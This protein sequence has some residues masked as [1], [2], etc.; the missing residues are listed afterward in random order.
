M[1][2]NVEVCSYFTSKDGES[3]NVRDQILSMIDGA[4]AEAAPG[5]RIDLEIYNKKWKSRRNSSPGK[6]A[7]KKKSKKLNDITIDED[8][9]VG[10]LLSASWDEYFREVVQTERYKDRCGSDVLTSL[11]EIREIWDLK[12]NYENMTDEERKKLLGTSGIYGWLGDMKHARIFMK[13]RHA[14]AKKISLALDEIP[15]DP[16]IEVTKDA[17]DAFLR[18]WRK[19]PHAALGVASRLLAVRR[20]DSFCSVNRRCRTKLQKALGIRDIKLDNYW[21]DC[22]GIIRQS[23]WWKAP[24]PA[25]IKRARLWD[26]RMALVDFLVCEE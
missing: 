18:H 7:A 21:D 17:Y 12:K 2:K 22:V 13:N 6:V 19:I 3:G 5:N 20:P 15:L 26:N 9:D 1:T 24:R 10:G 23:A 25:N 16:N 8:A 11:A 14:N 4:W